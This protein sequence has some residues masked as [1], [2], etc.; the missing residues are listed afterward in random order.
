MK[1]YSPTHGKRNQVLP[2]APRR[3]A[4]EGQTW[5]FVD[6]SKVNADLFIEEMKAEVQHHYHPKTFTVIRK[7]SPGVPLSSAQI[8][9][10]AAECGFVVFCFGD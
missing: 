6:T 8:E 10:L 5:G 1:I 7:E 4:L 3:R 9:H 2:L